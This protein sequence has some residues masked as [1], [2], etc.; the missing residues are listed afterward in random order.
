[1]TYDP[2]QQVMGW[3]RRYFGGG[4]LGKSACRITDPEGKRDQIWIAA[5]NGGGT[6][7]VLRHGEDLGNRRRPA[8][9]FFVDAG[10]SYSARR[11]R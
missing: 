7:W 3:C 1:M 6:Y 5:D 9:A 4:S 2:E 11:R 8:D 10:L